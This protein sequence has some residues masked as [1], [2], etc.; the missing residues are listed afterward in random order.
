MIIDGSTIN[1]FLRRHN[2][3]IIITDVIVLIEFRFLVDKWCCSCV[4]TLTNTVVVVVVVA[5]AI[6]AIAIGIDGTFV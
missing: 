6:S 2:R 1:I 5:A 4:I 3:C